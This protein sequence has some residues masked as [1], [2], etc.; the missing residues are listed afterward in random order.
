MPFGTDRYINLLQPPRMGESLENKC[1]PFS[2]TP[3]PWGHLPPESR[4]PKCVS[5]RT[6]DLPPPKTSLAQPKRFTPSFMP[7]SPHF[8]GEVETRR[9]FLEHYTKLKPSWGKAV[10]GEGKPP[11][12]PPALAPRREKRPFGA[13]SYMPRKNHAMPQKQSRPIGKL[14][15]AEMAAWFNPPTSRKEQA[16]F[17]RIAR[18]Y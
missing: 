7:S 6:P 14:G 1:G 10:G 17:G 18:R 9:D 15:I 12:N 4:P 16:R 3:R 11:P 8:K 13:V 5:R 2:S